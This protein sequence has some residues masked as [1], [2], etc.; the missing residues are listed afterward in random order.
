MYTYIYTYIY[1]YIYIYMHVTLKLKVTG[2]CSVLPCV[3][4][5]CVIVTAL[6]ISIECCTVLQYVA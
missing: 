6:S 4:V 1:I 3:A 5:C 2:C